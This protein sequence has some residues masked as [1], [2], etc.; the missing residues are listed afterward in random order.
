MKIIENWLYVIDK[1]KRLKIKIFIRT[2]IPRTSFTVLPA[3]NNL[4]EIWSVPPVVG[5]ILFLILN[6][7]T[8]AKSNKGILKNNKTGVKEL[9]KI[10]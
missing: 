3:F 5:E 1:D 9:Y 10:F 8:V 6:V 4:C 7:N 2:K